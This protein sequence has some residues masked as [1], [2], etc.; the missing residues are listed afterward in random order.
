MSNRAQELRNIWQIMRNRPAWLSDMSKSLVL[1]PD[2]EEYL[3]E[4]EDGYRAGL[5]E[6][7]V[8][9]RLAVR[10]RGNDLRDEIVQINPMWARERRRDYLETRLK[11]LDGEIAAVTLEALA[12]QNLPADFSLIVGVLQRL[13]QEHR[14][15]SGQLRALEGKNKENRLTDQQIERARGRSLEDILIEEPVKGYI[16]CPLHAE[17]TGQ[18][19]G[20]P[21][22]LVR[23]GFGYCFSCAGHVDALGYMMKVRGLP[24][25][26]AVE[27]LQ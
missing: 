1:T 26:A 8:A 9:W 16:P 14:R 18:P 15:L 2:E 27:A 25:R 23:G 19:D 11:L 7:E 10:G 17:R 20:H 22:M 21:S 5:R 13:E 6:L 4:L 24:F 3:S 12:V